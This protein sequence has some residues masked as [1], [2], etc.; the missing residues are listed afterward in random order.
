MARAAKESPMSQRVRRAVHVILPCA[1]ACL[2]GGCT[3]ESQEGD[4]TVFTYAL[5]VPGVVLAGG[6]VGTLA[7]V[8]IRKS[9]ERLGWALIIGGPV[10]AFIFAPGLYSDKI[11]VSNERFTLRTGFW[12]APTTHEVEL[13]DVSLTG[14]EQV[15]AL[16]LSVNRTARGKVGAGTRPSP[17]DL[18][19]QVF[20]IKPLR[21]ALHVPFVNRPRLIAASWARLSRM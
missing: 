2:L 16:T 4:T 11:T 7:G 20:A 14:G 3:N 10:A 8:L 18:C 9:I 15:F 5:W 13:A 6:I 1:F 19:P 21:P 12:F 17:G